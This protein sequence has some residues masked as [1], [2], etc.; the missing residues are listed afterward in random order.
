MVDFM[1]ACMPGA[2]AGSAAAAIS[3]RMRAES[4]VN[5]RGLNETRAGERSVFEVHHPRRSFV[6]ASGPRLD[7]ALP[8]QL[9]D[10]L[11]HDVSVR[12]EHRMVEL[13]VR[14]DLHGPRQ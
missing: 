14:H 5:S 6:E 3:A 10:Q 11:P 1:Y 9:F 12:A 2:R 4:F 7:H 8:D 13:G